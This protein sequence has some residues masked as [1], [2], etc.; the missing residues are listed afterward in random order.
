M[1]HLCA[2]R[3]WLRGPARGGGLSPEAP[4]WVCLLPPSAVSC[5]GRAGGGRAH[6]LAFCVI[7]LLLGSQPHQAT[8]RARGPLP[9]AGVLCRGGAAGREGA[10]GAPAGGPRP[11]LSLTSPPPPGTGPGHVRLP[12]LQH[13]CQSGRHVLS[14]ICFP[15]TPSAKHGRARPS[16][17]LHQRPAHLLRSAALGRARA[18]TGHGRAGRA[19]EE[20]VPG[21]WHRPCCSRPLLPGIRRL[22]PPRHSQAH[23]ESP[24]LRE[25]RLPVPGTAGSPTPSS[26]GHFPPEPASCGRQRGQLLP[27]LL[28]GVQRAAREGAGAVVPGGQAQ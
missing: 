20:L 17:R 11:L 23:R 4:L 5:R 14:G 3:G 13:S 16:P 1:Q 9:A 10:E 22:P 7:S 28:P 8:P 15:N 18:P 24:A 6:I 12:R 27:L 2:G 25:L 26:W 19:G 21:S